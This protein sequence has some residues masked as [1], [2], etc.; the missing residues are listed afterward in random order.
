MAE[1]S[2]SRKGLWSKSVVHRDSVSTLE[3]FWHIASHCYAYCLPIQ[4]Y[5]VVPMLNGSSWPNIFIQK[6]CGQNQ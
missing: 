2:S 3:Y 6:G 5:T 4:P 1:I